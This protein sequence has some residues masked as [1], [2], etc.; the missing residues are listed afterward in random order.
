M[1]KTIVFGGIGMAVILIG[2]Q[3]VTQSAY[4]QN[5]AGQINYFKQQLANQD[6]TLSHQPGERSVF[7]ASD[8]VTV[9]LGENHSA[10][11]LLNP[12]GPL[13]LKPSMSVHYYPSILP[14]MHVSHR[15]VRQLN[16]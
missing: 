3:L 14:V 2:G 16:R 9:S 5:I 1:K 7:S 15:L 13:P 12:A 6:I 10:L 11:D 4:D 8:E